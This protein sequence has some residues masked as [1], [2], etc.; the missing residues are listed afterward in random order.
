MSQP[1]VIVGNSSPVKSGFSNR[2]KLFV[3]ATLGGGVAAAHYAFVDKFSNSSKKMPTFLQ[4][5]KS[6]LANDYGRIKGFCSKKW[7]AGCNKSSIMNKISTSWKNCSP[8][9]Q[10]ALKA[11]GKT[12]VATVAL[13]TLYN[14]LFAKKNV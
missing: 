14:M 9:T 8:K 5:W 1:V 6:H 11:G 10:Q 2:K 3:A 12:A 4:G 7:A 13:M